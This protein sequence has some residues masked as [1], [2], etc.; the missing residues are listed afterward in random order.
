MINNASSNAAKFSREKR[1]FIRFINTRK[2]AF[3]LFFDNSVNSSIQ[4]EISNFIAIWSRDFSGTN[5]RSRIAV[6][7]FYRTS[8]IRKFS[9]YTHKCINFT[10][11]GFFPCCTS[12]CTHLISLLIDDRMIKRRYKFGSSGFLEDALQALQMSI[13]KQKSITIRRCFI[14]L[15][16]PE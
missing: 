9:F 15:F 11:C 3:A 5:Y 16:T 1:D 7:F 8:D 6:G 4:W 13:T 2:D 12:N 14:S 10:Q